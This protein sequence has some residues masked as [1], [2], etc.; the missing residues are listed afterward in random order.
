M[1]KQILTNIYLDLIELSDIKKQKKYWL[2]IN[3]KSEKI[4]SYIELMCRLFDDNCFDNFIDVEAQKA[5]FSDRII[6]EL[7]QLRKLLNMYQE[8]ASDEEIIKDKDWN[9]I[10]IQ[11]LSVIKLWNEESLSIVN[12]ILIFYDAH[13]EG[14]KITNNNITGKVIFNDKSDT[15]NFVWDKPILKHPEIINVILLY[16][17]NNKLHI[18][19]KITILLDDLINKIVNLSYNKNDVKNAIDEMLDIKIFMVDDGEKNDY[20]F[21]HF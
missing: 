1:K 10:V 9:K 4:S 5:G 16:L 6:K 19:D 20:F 3:N 12:S 7:N 13:S 14:I 21:I 18:N 8:K 2:N 15:Q 17:I 11:A